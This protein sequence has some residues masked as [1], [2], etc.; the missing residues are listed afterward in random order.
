MGGVSRND[1]CLFLVIRITHT[2]TGKH[3]SVDDYG[4]TTKVVCSRSIQSRT[5]WALG[6]A[7]LQEQKAVGVAL[8]TFVTAV[9][10]LDMHEDCPAF[11]P[12]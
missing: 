1:Y 6:V 2:I 9:A 4:K 3:F 11:F 12:R 10:T 5:L 8:W 7:V